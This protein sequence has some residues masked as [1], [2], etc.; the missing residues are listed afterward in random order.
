[1]RIIG[2]QFRSRR[3][4]APRGQDTRPTLD[5]TRESLFNILGARVEGQLVLDLFA[6]SGVMGLEAISRGASQAVFCDISPRACRTVEGNIAS[7]GVGERCR[8]LC[9]PWQRALTWLRTEGVVP[10]LV[11]VDPPYGLDASP[12]LDALAQP[13]MLT[14]DALILLERDRR[15]Q[16]V[17]P[18]A[19]RL[20][21]TKDYADTRVDFLV[22]Q[23]G[24]T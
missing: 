12:V 18:G 1:M 13:G 4:Q 14:T 17:I 7:L 11:F 22:L 5:G 9:M 21:R 16:P 8:V 20:V 10:G 15:M 24:T 6:G 3:L 23:G 2:G 19:L